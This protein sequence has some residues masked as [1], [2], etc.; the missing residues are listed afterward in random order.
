VLADRQRKPTNLR[1]ESKMLLE[2]IGEF[3]GK[4]T[5]QTGRVFRFAQWPDREG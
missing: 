2:K 4:V 1:V 5:G 3:R